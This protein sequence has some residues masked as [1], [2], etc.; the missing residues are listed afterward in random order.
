[1]PNDYVRK[2]FSVVGLRLKKELEGVSVLDLEE[3]ANK[4]NIATTR[5]FDTTYTEK[6]YLEERISTFAATCVE[7][8]RNQHSTCQI[9][10][11][12][13]NTNR[14]NEMHEQYYRSINVTIPF[15]TNSSIEIAKYAKMY[16]FKLIWT[17]SCRN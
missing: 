11:V 4:K 14:F 17:P 12:F 9:V 3:V 15:A 6:S 2:E 16:V 1:L 7:K 10:T 13:V 5:S 8:L